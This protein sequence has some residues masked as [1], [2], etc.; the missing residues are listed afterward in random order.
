M[1]KF[2]ENASPKL[3]GPTRSAGL[4]K[5]AAQS[6]RPL[7][8]KI[9]AVGDPP[10]PV[11]FMIISPPHV[12]IGFHVMFCTLTVCTGPVRPETTIGRFTPAGTLS[13]IAAGNPAGVHV[14]TAPGVHVPVGVGV[15][16]GGA[17]GLDVGVGVG[18]GVP[19]SSLM[20]MSVI[21]LG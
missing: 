2:A 13:G 20:A 4:P 18:V 21:W 10:G 16:L 7:R 3:Y 8:W 1:W 15:A 11:S 19:P 17:V 9:V 12:C 14:V 5:P 6:V